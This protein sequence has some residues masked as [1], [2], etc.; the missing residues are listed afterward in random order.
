M[1]KL[2]KTSTPGIFRRHV[3][4]CEGEGRCECSY[5]VVWRHRGKQHKQTFRTA[6]E[7]REAQGQRKAGDGRPSTRVTFEGYF[8]EWIKTYAGRTSQGLSDRSRDLYR[9]AIEDHV[10]KRWGGWKL[11]DIEPVDVRRLYADLREA[12]TSTSVLRL[13]RASISALFATAVEDGVLR[14]SPVTGVRIPAAARA[15][16]EEEPAK[17]LTKGELR[18]LQAAMPGEDWR[19]FFLFLTHTGL[20]ISEALGVTW[21][22]VELGR[23]PRLLVREQVYEGSRQRLK[24]RSGRREIPLSPGMAERLRAHRRDNFRGEAEPVFTTPTGEGL[25][26]SNVAN[27]VLHPAAKAAGLTVERD[28]EQVPWVSFHTFR[29][30]C[31]SLLFEAGRNVKQVSEWLGHSDPSFTLST[32]VHLL[33]D[34]VGDADFFDDALQGNRKATQG[35]QTTANP[36]EVESSETA[37]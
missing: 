12:G 6:A 25:R 17:A 9:R 26:R 2:T 3:A 22:H 11:S 30:T 31:A 29:H 23:R 28:G 8:A 34:G 24:S 16:D 35:L 13:V 20:R 18:L 33:D 36:A 4:G 27:R 5:V 1:A 15:A 32:Y 19:L 21:R 37:R 10:V 14:S 7:A